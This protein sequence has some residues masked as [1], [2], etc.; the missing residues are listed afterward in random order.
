MSEGT[1]P[2]P[3]IEKILINQLRVFSADA[4]LIIKQ[5]KND[6]KKALEEILGIMKNATIKTSIG[7]IESSPLSELDKFVLN[8]LYAS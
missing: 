6:N 4:L 7:L 2:S 1:N 8:R 5:K 3:D